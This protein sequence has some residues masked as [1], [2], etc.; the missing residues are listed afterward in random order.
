MVTKK[1][2]LEGLPNDAEAGSRSGFRARRPRV[3]TAEPIEAPLFPGSFI[4]LGDGTIEHCSAE[5]RA[6]LTV[7]GFE[8]AMTSF[9]VGLDRTGAGEASTNRRANPFEAYAEASAVR[10]VGTGAIARY[11]VRIRPRGDTPIE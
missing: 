4:V 7:R 10:L 11:H 3:T 1:Q 6:W 2:A 8:T 5:S 9:V